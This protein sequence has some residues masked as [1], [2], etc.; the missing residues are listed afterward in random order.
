MDLEILKIASD[1]KNHR[2]LSDCTHS[3]KFKNPICGDHMKINIKIK[4]N[5]ILDF[6]YI[7][8]SCIYCQAS[9]SLLAKLSKNKSLEK[10]KKISTLAGAFFENNNPIFPKEWKQ[11]EKLFNKKNTSR[12]ECILLP[13]KTL[14][15]ALKSKYGKK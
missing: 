9:A 2:N 15:K 1:T 10:I 7:C 4:N 14:T 5:K 8:K 13:F 11:F 12:K 3:S 6:A